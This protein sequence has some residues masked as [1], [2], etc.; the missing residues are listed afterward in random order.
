MPAFLLPYSSTS[1]PPFHTKAK[2]SGGYGTGPSNCS[3]WMRLCGSSIGRP[4]KVPRAPRSHLYLPDWLQKYYSESPSVS[5][6]SPQ[7]RTCMKHSADYWGATSGTG[8]YT[9]HIWVKGWGVTPVSADYPPVMSVGV[10]P[11]AV[12]GLRWSWEPI[13]GAGALGCALYK[14]DVK[15]LWDVLHLTDR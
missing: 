5:V 3:C 10:I 15:K 6:A 11:E 4:Q 8:S 7:S 14:N 9:S 12:P 2:I 1:L 13:K